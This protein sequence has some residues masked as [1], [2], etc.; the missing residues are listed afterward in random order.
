L[1]Q[2]TPTN[3]QS[4]ALVKEK[5]PFK[6][7]NKPHI[8]KPT[9][10]PLEK[11]TLKLPELNTNLNLSTIDD[12]SSMIHSPSKNY[13]SVYLTSVLSRK[14]S[15]VRRKADQGVEM[16]AISLRQKEVDFQAQLL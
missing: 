13:Q 15:S 10:T 8:I 4:A 9:L 16:F 11:S 5:Q 2:H 14:N 12:T 7:L 1:S 6:P 3:S